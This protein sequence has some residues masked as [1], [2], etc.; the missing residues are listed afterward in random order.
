MKKLPGTFWIALA[1][2]LVSAL[3]GFLQGEFSADLVW[4]PIAVIALE[5]IFKAL[6]VAKDEL[7]GADEFGRRKAV[8]TSA[9]SKFD[10]WF[11]GG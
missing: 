10:R 2:A 5:A 8:V 3:I 4:A 1:S 6:E 7:P 9:H 11:W